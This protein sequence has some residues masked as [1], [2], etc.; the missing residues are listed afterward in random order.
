MIFGARLIIFAPFT[1]RDME[2]Y[3]ASSP[4]LNRPRRHGS[5]SRRH[6]RMATM[7][8][9]KLIIKE[10]VEETSR[11]LGRGSYGMVFE[12][13]VGELRCA[14][15]RLHETFFQEGNAEEKQLIV[16]KFADECVQLSDLRHPNI[17]QLLGLYF[18][19]NSSVTLVTELLPMNLT[20]CLKQ[21]PKELSYSMKVSILKDVSLGLQYLHTRDKPIIHRDLTANNILLTN[22][23]QA[24]IIDF[25][26]AKML[27]G[28]KMECM[29]MV[30]GAQ[31]AMP[32]EAFV[33]DVDGVLSYDTKLDI[34][35]F[36]HLILNVVTQRLIPVMPPKFKIDPGNPKQPIVVPEV[37]RRAEYLEQ[38]DGES[39]NLKNLAI[40]CLE[41]APPDRPT[42]VDTV[43]EMERISRVTPLLYTNVA[44]MMKSV[45][46]KIE[47]IKRLR[48]KLSTQE[49]E[50]TRLRYELESY[51]HQVVERELCIEELKEKLL[52]MSPRPTP[53]PRRPRATSTP[54]D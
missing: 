46:T 22:S 4:V 7:I 35:S 8:L 44:D 39:L 16:N 48:S 41:D 49:E 30:P 25:G 3:A 28:T 29:T 17:V 31:I 26:M 45:N 33:A 38:M 37:T 18:G 51:K 50:M 24:K 20:H 23:L 2:G 52:Q 53:R 14:G 42:T 40:K 5:G 1:D 32:P 12:I 27:P 6:S 21:Y 11:E 47:Q 15:K 9:E 19:D 10:A 34:F 54:D 13:R 36:G 43:K